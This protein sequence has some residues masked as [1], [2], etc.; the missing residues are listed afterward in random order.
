M[1]NNFKIGEQR[2]LEIIPGFLVWTTFVL[3]IGLSFVKPLWVI[4]FIIIFDLYWLIRISYFV[5]WMFIGW[6][7]FRREA[8][9]DWFL[10]V[11]K[12]D[13]WQDIYHVVFLPTF[14]ESFDVL[15]TTFQGLVDSSYPKDKFIVVL[16]GEARDKEN[17]EKISRSIKK[18]FAGKFFRLLIT[19][20]PKNLKGEIP[21]KGS[22]SHWAGHK[23]KELVDELG[24]PYDKIIV[25]NFDIDTIVHQQYFA[26]ITHAFLTHPTPL[27]TSF[28]PLALYNNNIFDA[29]SFARVVANSTTFWLMTELARPERMFTFSSHSMPWQALVDVGFW[30]KTIV[31]EDSR[32]FLQCF[33]HYDGEYTITPIYIPVSMDTVMGRNLWETIK[34]QYKQQRRWA[35]GVEHFPW[36]MR[37]FRANKK[38][39]W[40]KKFKYIF[41]QT[42]GVYS[43]ATAPILI[44]LLGRLPLWV[45]GYQESPSVIIQNAPFLLERLMQLAMLGIFISAALNILLLPQGHTK[46]SGWK[47]VSIVLQWILLPVTLLTF[48]SFP[49]TDAQTRLMLGKYLGFWTTQKVRK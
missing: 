39:P 12:I 23:A 4:Y 43:W 21:G 35:W 22:N 3:S 15:E 1:L 8:K 17:F 34:A 38:I 48:G 11:G 6:F 26:R 45:A 47:I 44:T 5:F 46:R 30:D 25:S 29:P 24:L 41:N 16:A 7:R 10:E 27:R 19:L 32:I 31:T 14:K 33:N 2:F 36:M 42:E 9:V 49:A 18:K 20:H 37:N 40:R 28:Q 13:G